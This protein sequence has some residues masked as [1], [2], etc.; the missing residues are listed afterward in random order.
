MFCYVYLFCYVHRFELTVNS[1]PF[2]FDVF[3]VAMHGRV[4]QCGEVVSML[5]L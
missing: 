1:N 2:H 3:K 5:D 4:E